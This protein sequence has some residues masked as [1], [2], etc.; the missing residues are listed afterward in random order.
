MKCSGVFGI[1][2]PSILS[3]EPPCGDIQVSGPEEIEVEIGIELLSTEKEG[4]RRMAKKRRGSGSK[5]ADTRAATGRRKRTSKPKR[6]EANRGYPQNTAWNVKEQQTG[7]G[8]GK[9][10]SLRSDKASVR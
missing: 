4:V 10:D 1:P 9:D 2:L 3:P 8:P 5:S 7:D 6:R